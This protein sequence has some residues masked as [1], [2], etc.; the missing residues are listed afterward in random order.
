[1]TEKEAWLE[2]AHEYETNSTPSSV[3]ERHITGLCLRINAFRSAPRVAMREHLSLFAPYRG[4]VWYWAA[5]DN[6]KRTR[7]LRAT[8]CCFLAAMCDTVTPKRRAKG[9]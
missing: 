9:S 7:D 8:A 5:C 4:A 2:L 3:A 6:S 1:M